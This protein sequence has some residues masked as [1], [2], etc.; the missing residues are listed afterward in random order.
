[1][2]IPC[3]PERSLAPALVASPWTCS[4]VATYLRTSLA[5]LPGSALDPSLG[6]CADEQNTVQVEE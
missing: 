1:M 5:R 4:T 6:G 3:Q 2:H